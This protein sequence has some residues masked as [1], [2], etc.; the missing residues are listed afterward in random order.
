MSTCFRSLRTIPKRRNADTRHS[1]ASQAAPERVENFRGAAWRYGP[2]A[3]RADQESG[4]YMISRT[5]WAH[6]QATAILAAHAS[7][8]SREGTSMIENPPRTALVSG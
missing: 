7:A 2:D 1:F 8:S 5:S 4:S 3:G 6:R